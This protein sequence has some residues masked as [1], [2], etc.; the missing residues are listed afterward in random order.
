M[1]RPSK[2]LRIRDSIEDMESRRHFDDCIAV[3]PRFYDMLTPDPALLQAGD[4]GIAGRG[5]RGHIYE[6]VKERRTFEIP[7]RSLIP[8]RIDNLLVAG[9]C[10]SA[11]HVAESGVRAISLCTMTGQAAGTAAALALRDRTVPAAIH[12]PELQ[13]RLRKDGFTLLQ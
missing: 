12:V 1:T 11:D 8:E 5:Y 7:Y 4:G 3:F 2:R 6:P 9:R 13:S 10:I